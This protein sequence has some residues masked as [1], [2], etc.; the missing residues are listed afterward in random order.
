MQGKKHNNDLYVGPQF[1][2]FMGHVNGKLHF[3]SLSFK[4]NLSKIVKVNF[5]K[6]N[7]KQFFRYSKCYGGEGASSMW[8]GASSM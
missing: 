1:G 7:N 2:K 6:I 3:K 8:G 5:T 4:E